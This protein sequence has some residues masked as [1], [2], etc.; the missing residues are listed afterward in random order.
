LK[1]RKFAGESLMASQRTMDEMIATSTLGLIGSDSPTLKKLVDCAQIRADEK[2]YSGLHLHAE[3]WIERKSLRKPDGLKEATAHNTGC[4]TR[5]RDWSIWIP[6]CFNLNLH[7]GHGR[8][9]FDGARR[10]PS[11]VMPNSEKPGIKQFN[12]F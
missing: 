9:S 5:P 6:R 7:V 2:V 8:C 12:S 11:T 4:T 10:T 3:R 1:F